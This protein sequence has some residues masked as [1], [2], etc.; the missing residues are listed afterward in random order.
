MRFGIVELPTTAH[1]DWS[2]SLNGEI[3]WRSQAHDLSSALANSRVDTIVFHL[4][5]GDARDLIQAIER[6][7]SLRPTTKMLLAATSNDAVLVAELVSVINS[8]EVRL[9]RPAAL[10]A[11][12]T[13]VLD[14]IRSGRT[15][16]E[17]AIALGISLSTANRHVENILKKLSARNRAQ[18]V[19]ETE[20]FTRESHQLPGV[21]HTPALT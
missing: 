21:E 4:N 13:Q 1:R 10:T 17:I 7:R 3:A 16:R 20:I 15:N 2:S 5:V 8:D 12:E 11:R 18:A 19:A 6:A 14:E 9:S